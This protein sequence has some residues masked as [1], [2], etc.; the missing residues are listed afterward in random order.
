MKFAIGKK[1]KNDTNFRYGGFRTSATEV[2]LEKIIVT[3]I[4]KKEKEGYDAVQIGYGEKK[5]KQTAK[6]KDKGIV[7]FEGMKELYVD[8]IDKYKI[9]DKIDTNDI[10]Q[11][12]DVVNVSGI[13]KGKGFAGVVKRHNFGGGPRSHG[14]KHTERSPGSIGGGLR[15]RVPKGVKMAGR[16]GGERITIKGLEIVLTDKDSNKILIKGSLPGKKGTLI[17]VK[18]L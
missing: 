9:G 4:C 14:Q 15:C 5:A 7:M 8:D 13:S 6:Q 18:T 16:M 10:F 1:T 12:G 17:E 2:I 11:K 3:K